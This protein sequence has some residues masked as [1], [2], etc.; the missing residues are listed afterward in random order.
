MVGEE[1]MMQ[2]LVQLPNALRFG[3]VFAFLLLTYAPKNPRLSTG[4]AACRC[5]LAVALLTL[6]QLGNS[7]QEGLYYLYMMLMY[8][9][10]ALLLRLWTGWNWCASFLRAIGWYLITENATLL[11]SHFSQKLFGEDILRG[12]FELRSALAMGALVLLAYGLLAL[13]RHMSPKTVHATRY[14]L[15]LSLLAMIPYLF[16]RQVTL[17]LPVRVEDVSMAIVTTLMCSALL[18][19]MFSVSLERLLNAENEKRRAMARQMEVERQQQQYMMRKHEIEA[20][21]QQYHD[22][23]NLLLYLE[24]SPSRE[25]I[26]AHVDKILSAIQPFESVLD[27]GNDAVDILLGEKLEVCRKQG[28]RCTVMVDG[29]SLSFIDQLDLVTILG[30]AMDNAVEACMNVRD[31][32]R[33]AIQVRTS[34]APGFVVLHIH[35][36]C[37]ESL[38]VQGKLPTTSK[39]DAENHGYGLRNIRRTVEKYH[40]EMHCEAKQGEFEL[41]LL[42]PYSAS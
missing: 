28:I 14:T 41:T 24:K 20:V 13:L 42:L 16:V 31:A 33:R 11:L 15:L 21:R 37:N 30:N 27:T 19:L 6:L 17:W 8:L 3:V 18:A 5:V 1:A 36:S 26:H 7:W 10:G 4:K 32:S 35:N 29:E 38:L 40:G 34:T 9:S 2:V 23:K 39:R 12:A 25:N 22:M